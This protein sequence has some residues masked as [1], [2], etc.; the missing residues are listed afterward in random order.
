MSSKNGVSFYESVERS[1]EKAAQHTNLSRGLLEQIKAC[2]AVYQMRFP[3]KIGN[4][5]QVIEAYR[6]QHSQHR[7]PTKGG[8]RYSM[9][10]N[11]DEVMALAALMSYKCAI[12]DVPFGGAKGGVKINPKTYTTSQL[13]R[14]TRRYTTELVRKKFI[15]PGIDVPAPDYGTGSREMAWILDTYMQL[16]QGEIDAV[17]CVTG[18]PVT[19]NGIRGRTEA[20]G[21]GVFYG[22][23]EACSYEEDMKKLGLTKGIA[24]KRMVVQGLGNVGSHT[25]MISQNEGDVIITG[26]AEY[27]GS[28]H[29]EDG[30]DIEA[31]LKHRK[32]TG[33][34]L[35]FPGA[36]NLPTREAAL[37][38]DCDILV[39]AALE[40]VIT[41]ENAPRIK[42]K[43]IAEAAN[44]PVTPDAEEI[45]LEKGCLI[46]PDMY[47]NAGGVTVS[48]FEW[49]KNLSHMRFGRMEK[50]FDHNTYENLVNL[51]EKMTGKRV[52]QKE[53]DFLTKGADEQDLVRSGLEETM[54]TA[55]QQF[56]SIWRRRKKVK[57]LR[58]A[59]FIN[60]IDK[61]ASDYLNMGIFP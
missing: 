35:N 5:Y 33:S 49:L 53:R 42:A 23:R 2:N 31:L 32:E 26:I 44:G 41:K 39:P 11:Q 56:H 12:V 28:I 58:T 8:I 1:F 48:Y 10:V 25:A 61:I 16:N 34:I 59:A 3:V 54:V 4:E 45:L 9:A 50:R 18:K 30:I 46:I 24:G 55:Y 19:Q 40:Q 7:L 60:A 36:T 37:E 47:I 38:L 17:A 14:I 27:E 29:K 57:D 13:Q 22:L 20:T 6:V 21:R 51:V 15:G 52:A 43:I